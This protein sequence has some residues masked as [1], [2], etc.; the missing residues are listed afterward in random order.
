MKDLGRIII[1]KKVALESQALIYK[2]HLEE[3]DVPCFLSNSNS[4]TVLPMFSSGVCI[5]VHESNKTTALEIMSKVDEMAQEETVFTHHDATH[6][7]I[8]YEK[9]VSEGKFNMK[10]IVQA[11]I[12]VIIIMLLVAY[13][14]NKVTLF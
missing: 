14:S 8:I 9:E 6:D 4:N 5:H 7:D 10:P 1:I 11:L 2:A 3:A 12:G 13:L